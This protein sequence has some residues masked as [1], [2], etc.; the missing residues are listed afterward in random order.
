MIRQSSTR[1][2][3]DKS[4]SA[5]VRRRSSGPTLALIVGASLLVGLPGTAHAYLDPASGSLFLQLLLG[6]IAGAALALK[7][8]W[9]RIT[10]FFSRKPSSDDSAD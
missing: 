2:R 9:H 6:G 1:S 10:G 8:F 4:L 3:A 5:P 7:L